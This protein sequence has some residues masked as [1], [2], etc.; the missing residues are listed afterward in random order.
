MREYRL[1]KI[2]W[3]ELLDRYDSELHSLVMQNFVKPLALLSL[4]KNIVLLCDC[5]N[6]KKCPDRILAKA[7]QE[8]VQHSYPE[9]L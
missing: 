5:H 4:R 7:L 2:E 8:Q 3:E 6:R 1:G 9:L